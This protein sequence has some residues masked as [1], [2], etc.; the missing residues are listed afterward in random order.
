VLEELL[1]LKEPRFRKEVEAELASSDIV[2]MDAGS[3]KL[4][5]AC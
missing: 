4:T 5:L 2:P 3:D 1:E